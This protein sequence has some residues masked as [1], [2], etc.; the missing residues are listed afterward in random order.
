EETAARRWP[1]FVVLFVVVHAALS[2]WASYRWLGLDYPWYLQGG[3]A[4]QYLLGAMF[5]PSTFGVL[6]VVA[7]CLFMRERPLWAAVC[8]G[9]SATVQTTYLL[10]GVV[11]TMG[12]MTALA[13]ERRFLAALGVGALALAL[14]L[15]VTLHVWLTFGPTSA[16]QFA[17]S[18]D[19][20][21]NFR[22]PHHSRVD[23]WLDPIAG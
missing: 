19:I 21:V 9:I 20:L 12:F 13:L 5:Q 3:L 11:L 8:I 7:I 6:L 10:P 23:L 4:G 16:T 14:V 1:V 18:Q 22:I 15:P 17:E 2:R